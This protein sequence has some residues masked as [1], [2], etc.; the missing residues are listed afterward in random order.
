M[1]APAEAKRPHCHSCTRLTVEAIKDF[2][3]RFTRQFTAVR[4]EGDLSSR[5]SELVAGHYRRCD[6]LSG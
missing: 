4:L 3:A 1:F 2:I 5:R 6:R